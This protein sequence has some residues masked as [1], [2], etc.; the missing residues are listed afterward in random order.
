METL[1]KRI[2]SVFN[3]ALPVGEGSG[4]SINDP[5]QVHVQEEGTYEDLLSRWLHFKSIL[6]EK[7]LVILRTVPILHH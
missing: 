3:I 5:V 1:Q 7:K 6:E 4:T 2:S